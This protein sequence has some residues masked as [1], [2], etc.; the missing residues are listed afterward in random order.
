MRKLKYKSEAKSWKI[1]NYIKIDSTVIL[2]PEI[3][4]STETEKSILKLIKF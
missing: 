3:L 4:L 1:Y 2:F